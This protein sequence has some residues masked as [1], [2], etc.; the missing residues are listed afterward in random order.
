MFLDLMEVEFGR[1]I[2]YESIVSYD[3]GRSL[4]LSPDQLDAFMVSAHRSEVL[5][6]IEPIEHAIEVLDHWANAGYTID[7]VTGRPTL[8]SEITRQWL[9]NRGVPYDSLTFVDKYSW[10]ESVFSGNSAVPLETVAESGFCLAVEDSASVASRLAGLIDTPV[11]LIDKPWNRL[12]RI[13]HD[14]PPGRVSRCV[15][16]QEISER[17]RAP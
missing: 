15:D 17:F 9:E 11:V 6:S 8:T 2:E 12:E 3:L 7:V 10:K 14:H 1:Q 4:D 5:L 16:W 13:E